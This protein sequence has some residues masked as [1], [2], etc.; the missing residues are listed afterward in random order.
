MNRLR[1]ARQAFV[2]LSPALHS[3]LDE[4]ISDRVENWLRQDVC[5]VVAELGLN[6]SFQRHARWSADH[7]SPGVATAERRL[8]ENVDR[9]LMQLAAALVRPHDRPTSRRGK[10]PLVSPAVFA[11]AEI[12]TLQLIESRPWFDL[13]CPE[14]Y[15]DA[16]RGLHFLTSSPTHTEAFHHQCEVRVPLGDY[17]ARGLFARIDYWTRILSPLTDRFLTRSPGDR[18]TDFQ[19]ANR[20]VFDRRIALEEAM[21]KLRAACHGD[22]SASLRDACAALTLV[23][24]AYAPMPRLEWLGCPSNWAET[25]APLI[26]TCVRRRG[27]QQIAERDSDGTLRIVGERPASLCD[28]DT[29][30][31]IAHALKDVTILYEMP[32][33]PADVVQWAFDYGKLVLVDGAP[34]AVYW[35][36]T[37]IAEGAWDRNEVQWNLLWTLADNPHTGVVQGMLLRSQGQA[38]ASRRSRLSRLLEDCPELDQ[39]IELIR[40]RGYR[41]DIDACDIVLLQGDGQGRLKV[42]NSHPLAAH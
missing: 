10:R 11:P 35:D 37:P 26:R 32:E 15:F 20:A 28:A 7:L 4:P 3:A 12:E 25:S 24:A 27:V 5:P 42:V 1:L 33:D 34:R 30:R 6:R 14:E 31:Q 23:Y 8:V 19:A 40:G 13:V 41:L 39:R 9:C 18:A 17:V 16:S 36:Q 29:V 2:S 38:I 21:V 22:D